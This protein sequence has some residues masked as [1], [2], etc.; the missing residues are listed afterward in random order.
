MT[1]AGTQTLCIAVTLLSLALVALCVIA[2]IMSDVDLVDA[3]AE[4]A[5]LKRQR[6]QGLVDLGDARNE[7]RKLQLEADLARA[8]MRQPLPMPAD[9]DHVEAAAWDDIVAN[10]DGRSDGC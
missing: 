8:P 5:E 10:F 3:H 4:I 6:H 1:P 7:L 2:L 9:I